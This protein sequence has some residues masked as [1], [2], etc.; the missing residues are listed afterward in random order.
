MRRFIY[1]LVLLISFNLS[2]AMKIP[3]TE[4]SQ[5]FSGY[6][7][8]NQQII[9]ENG[10][11]ETNLQRYVRNVDSATCEEPTELELR[12]LLHD[13][14]YVT[15]VG[16]LNTEDEYERLMT[17]IRRIEDSSQ[18]C[19]LLHVLSG[20]PLN[21]RTS[22]PWVEITDYNITRFPREITY[23]V[24]ACQNCIDMR[25]ASGFTANDCRHVYV[26]QPMLI[27]GEC[28]NNVYS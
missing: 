3:L 19:P 9:T 5:N 27:R 16:Q 22:C 4:T 24:C 2:L 17:S 20:V 28:L 13:A 12:E 6:E 23:A 11:R 1:L 26:E 8:S 14:V 7:A 18:H 15:R 10:E 25:E 21:R